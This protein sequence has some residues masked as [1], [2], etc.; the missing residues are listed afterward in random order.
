MLTNTVNQTDTGATIFAKGNYSGWSHNYVLRISGGE[1]VAD[2]G[3]LETWGYGQIEVSNAV[4]NVS[5]CSEVLNGH[6]HPGRIR[7]LDG[8]VVDAP[9]VRLSQSPNVTAEIYLGTGGVFKVK[10]F[11]IDTGMK[12][13]YKG[14]FYFD[15]GKT[16]TKATAAAFFGDGTD[17]YT[18][19]HVR[20]M[21][22]G[23]KFDTNGFV[24]RVYPALEGDPEG[25]GGLVKSGEN[26]LILHQPCTYTG[27]T[28][29]AEG[30]LRLSGPTNIL[31][32]GS[33]LILGTNGVCEAQTDHIGT[34]YLG[35]GGWIDCTQTLARVEG[36]GQIIHS[37]H[38]SVTN[39]VAPGLGK[40]GIG[41]LRFETA[42]DLR[43]TLEIDV[44]EE[45]ADCLNVE[46]GTQDLTN[47]KLKLN[48]PET[49]TPTP[50]RKYT[51]VSAPSGFA[52][53]FADTNLGSS[54]WKIASKNGAIV[55]YY[56]RG[57]TISFR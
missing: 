33:T 51:I 30:T 3:Y 16:V 49:F 2:G 56:V 55:L 6:G 27:A 21:K 37:S 11:K 53:S 47:L 18:N 43:G 40:G 28:E 32:P 36:C 29:I 4:L 17:Y 24:T 15:G 9:A 19:C 10:T 12:K 42:C 44:N 39:S 25:S 50:G 46:N 1:V 52:G 48:V 41:T 8:G 34:T 23:A 22:G 57:L 45:G 14:V 13:P 5:K 31:W 20:V 35:Q 7:V 54:R 26:Y 38:V